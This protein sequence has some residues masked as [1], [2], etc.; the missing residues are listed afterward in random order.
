M[1]TSSARIAGLGTTIFAEMSA[2]AVSTGAINL[3]QGF[4]DTDG[5]SSVVDVAVSALRGGRNQYAPGIGVPELRAAIA[6]HQQ[7]FYELSVDPDT[8]VAVTTGA[9]EAVAAAVLGLVD[10]GDEVIVL[11]PYYDSYVAVL[12][13]AGALRRPV[14]LR[15]PDFRLPVDELRA[16]VSPRTTAILLNSPHNPTGTVLR[17]G[18]LEAVAAVAQEHDLVVISDEVYEH[19]TFGVPHIPIATLPGM[20]ERTLTISSGGKSFSFTG[21]KVGWASGPAALVAAMVGVKQFLTYTSGSP[22]QPAIAAAL[23]SDDA[24]FSSL[25]AQMQLQ[26]DLLCDGLSAVGFEVFVPEGT[27][28]ATTDIRPLGFEDGMD[29]CRQLPALAGV[30][31]IP[32]QVFYDDISAGTPLVRWAFCKRPEV[33][34]EALNRLAVLG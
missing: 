31:A 27:Y 28:F 24:Y 21:W 17:R 23:A 7:R 22:L 20:A 8:E 6:L 29:F 34:A 33:I 3:G 2:L 10:P 5:P 15:A 9:T 30:V 25:I 13:M 18:E 19:L 32:H 1:K 11:E 4:P 14:T 16:A 26:R 12:Q